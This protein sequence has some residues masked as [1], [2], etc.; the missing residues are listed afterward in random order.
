MEN[1]KLVYNELY[2]LYCSAVSDHYE[3]MRGETEE[4]Y[5]L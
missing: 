2:E 4:Y 5:Y 1:G 3:A